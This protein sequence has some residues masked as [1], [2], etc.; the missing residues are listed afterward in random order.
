NIEPVSDALAESLSDL[1]RSSNI[2][3]TLQHQVCQHLNLLTALQELC[4]GVQ[5]TDELEY[6]E[7]LNGVQEDCLDLSLESGLSRMEDLTELRVLSVMRMK[8]KIRLEEVKWMVAHWPKLEAIPGL[9]SSATY[10]ESDE[11]LEALQDEEQ[12]I[13][14]WIKEHKPL[15]KYGAVVAP[16]GSLEEQS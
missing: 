1:M 15:L 3:T 7:V 16:K 10:E 4:L 13:I 8:H 11:E 9:L 5:P 12:H 6:R 14:H 2:G